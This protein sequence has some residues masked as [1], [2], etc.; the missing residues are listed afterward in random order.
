MKKY[1]I[2]YLIFSVSLGSCVQD[3]DDVFDK[4]PSERIE[5]AMKYYDNLLLSA[6][7]GWIVEYYP[8]ATQKY[9]GFVLYF[10]FEANDKVTV[11]SELAGTETEES[12]YSIKA[13]M[14]PTLNFDS[15]N[16]I[17]NYFSDPALNVGGGTGLGYEGDYEFILEEGVASEIILRGKKTSN[18]IRMTPLADGTT[19]EQYV[20][21]IQL[22]STNGVSTQYTLTIEEE[23][24]PISA[25]GRVFT[26]TDD[27]QRTVNAPFIFAP[28]GLKFYE[29]VMI[30]GNL[31]QNFVFDPSS[32]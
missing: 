27:T 30:K 11:G 25:S 32:E 16:S 12:V 6:N 31:L 22:M 15:Y 28:V 26:I 7:N 23:Y 3:V 18:T 14:G 4:S 20:E 29:P 21:E 5:E 1:L 17:L 13:D 19:W 2:L 24:Y 8:E 10:K 9:G